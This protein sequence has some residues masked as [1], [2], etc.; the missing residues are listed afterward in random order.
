MR[1]NIAIASPGDV[2]GERE[3]VPKV[4]TRWNAKRTCH[5]APSHVGVSVSS[6]AIIHNTFLT[7]ALLKRAIC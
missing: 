2:I 4:F 3:A 6:S 7:R 5:V 1:V